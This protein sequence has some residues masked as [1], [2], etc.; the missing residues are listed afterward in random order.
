MRLQSMTLDSVISQEPPSQHHHHGEVSTY[1][2]WGDA[3]LLN[4][5]HPKTHPVMFQVEISSPR[6]H[7]ALM[8]ISV[9]KIGKVVRAKGKGRRLLLKCAYAGCLSAMIYELSLSHS[10][11][12][13][14]KAT[15]LFR[16]YTSRKCVEGSGQWVSV[17]LSLTSPRSV[18]ALMSTAPR[19][20]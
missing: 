3:N 9:L 5:E 12:W 20:V 2:I 8:G 15:V 18:L 10:W 14:W 19:G 17:R 16:T 7:L 6:T 13:G 4:T 11:W 1:G